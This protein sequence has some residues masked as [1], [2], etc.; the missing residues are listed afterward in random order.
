MVDFGQARKRI[1]LFY[2][3]LLKQLE[4]KKESLKAPKRG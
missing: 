3:E 2:A 4:P 1:E